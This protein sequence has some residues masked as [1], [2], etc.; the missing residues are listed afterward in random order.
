MYLDR[1]YRPKRR[2]S[3]WRFLWLLVI[4]AVVAIVL[5]EQQPVWLVPSN[6]QPTPIPTRGALS[7]LADAQSDL[8]GGDYAAAIGSYRQMIRLEPNDATAYTRLSELYLLLE[9]FERS[10]ENAQQAVALEPENPEALTALARIQDWRDEYDDAIN[11]ALDS[12]EIDPENATTLAVIGEI[13]TDVGNWDVAQQY[14]EQALEIEPDNVLALRNLAHLYE[15]Q[16]DYEISVELYKQ[17]IEVAPDRFDLYIELGR[18]YRVGLYEYDLANDAYRQAVEAYE[19]AVTLDALGFGLYNV[20]DHLQA[21]RVLRDAVELDPNH[22]PALVH[23]GMALY[24]RRNY[25]DAVVALEKGVN[26]LGDDA[27]IEHIYTLGL[28][29]IYKN[30]T[31]CEKAEVWLLKALEIDPETGPAIEGLALCNE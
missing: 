23:L 1:S 24:A 5:Y 27:R 21:V 8:A 6:L 26:I 9:D 2:R 3:K 15:W 30:P 29:H 16:G 17:A 31:E 11:N 13:Y 7:Y 14:L 22:G 18:Q 12:Q 20:G 28:G 19:S 10:Y 25:E 4:L